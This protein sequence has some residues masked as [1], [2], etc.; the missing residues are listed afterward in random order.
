M[1]HDVAHCKMEDCPKKDTC[2][3]YQAWLEIKGTDCLIAVLMPKKVPCEY[4]MTAD[5]T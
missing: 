4:Y 5:K 3:R 2:Y 1:V